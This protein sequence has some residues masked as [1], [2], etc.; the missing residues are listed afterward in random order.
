MVFTDRRDNRHAGLMRELIRLPWL[1]RLHR[2]K[3][4]RKLVAD[5]V[6][7]WRTWFATGAASVPLATVK[8]ATESD[9]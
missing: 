2:R 1:H 8:K 9:R 7:Q 6:V 3:R 5:R 4:C